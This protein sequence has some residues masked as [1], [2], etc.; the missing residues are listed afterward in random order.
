MLHN[1]NI[2]V[3]AFCY[4]AKLSGTIERHLTILVPAFS[5]VAVGAFDV[6]VFGHHGYSGGALGCHDI[7]HG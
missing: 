5:V 4:C 2:N 1:V 7:A 3:I 6:R